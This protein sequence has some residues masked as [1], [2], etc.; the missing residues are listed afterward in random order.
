MRGDWFL[1][2]CFLDGPK[3][4]ENQIECSAWPDAR[5]ESECKLLVKY[6]DIKKSTMGD[7][8]RWRNVG[9]DK[10]NAC[11]PKVFLRTTL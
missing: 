10:S 5:D 3:H 11:D 6:T 1:G 2:K 8:R 9:C 4:D 7:S